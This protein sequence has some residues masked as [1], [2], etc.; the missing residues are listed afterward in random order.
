[1]TC[2]RLCEPLALSHGGSG[3]D[4]RNGHVLG[5]AQEAKF[6]HKHAMLCKNNQF[7]WK[8]ICPRSRTAFSSMS[9]MV[10]GRLKTWGRLTGSSAFQWKEISFMFSLSVRQPGYV[11]YFIAIKKGMD[12]SPRNW[13]LAPKARPCKQSQHFGKDL[14]SFCSL[15]RLLQ[16]YFWM[17]A[18]WKDS[19]QSQVKVHCH[20]S[21][22]RVVNAV[23]IFSCLLLIQLYAG[24]M[25]VYGL[26]VSAVPST[27]NTRPFEM[28]SGSIPATTIRTSSRRCPRRHVLAYQ[29]FIPCCLLIFQW[30]NVGGT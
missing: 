30:C 5:L 27:R 28:R 11:R 6:L 15:E 2:R 23:Y 18:I 20:H 14:N 13:Q 10:M 22:L 21:V 17:I 1:M 8:Y 26:M 29:Q 16:A 4:A 7:R 9:L 12:D 19:E 25:L 24:M 3:L